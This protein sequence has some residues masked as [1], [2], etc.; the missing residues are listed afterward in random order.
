MPPKQNIVQGGN[1]KSRASAAPR[2]GCRRRS[3]SEFESET[4]QPSATH[5]RAEEA[6]QPQ[7]TMSSTVK[8][9]LLEGNTSSTDMKLNDFLRS[10]LGDR[11]AVDEDHNVTMEMFVQEP[12]AYVQDQQLLRRILNLTEYQALEAI[13]RLHHEGVFSLGQWRGFE[14]RI[15]LLYLQGEK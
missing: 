3:R 7:W 10:N 14:G 6:R 13:S 12:D 2:V 5:I 11:A 4:D 15:R 8:D 1:A 9:I